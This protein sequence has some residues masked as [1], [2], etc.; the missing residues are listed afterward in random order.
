MFTAAKC[1]GVRSTHRTVM[2]MIKYLL[3]L[4]LSFV[5]TRLMLIRLK[6]K[7]SPTKK[8]VFTKNFEVS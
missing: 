1:G 4:S 3:E 8:Q 5:P 2:F 6:M 7:L